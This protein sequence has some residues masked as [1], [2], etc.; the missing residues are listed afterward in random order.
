M[1]EFAFGA[2]AALSLLAFAVVVR[3]TRFN[4]RLA[5]TVGLLLQ[6]WAAWVMSRTR[7]SWTSMATASAQP[8]GV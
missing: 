2:Y 6:V 5:L 4:A 8:D 7:C 1:T 3:A